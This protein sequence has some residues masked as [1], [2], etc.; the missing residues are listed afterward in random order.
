MNINPNTAQTICQILILVFAIL[1]V[2][3]CYGSYHFGKKAQEQQFNDVQKDREEKHNSM[4]STIEQSQSVSQKEKESLMPKLEV[5]LFTSHTKL[6]RPDGTSVAISTR[7]K[8]PLVE[9]Q[10]LISNTNNNSVLATD[11]RIKFFFSNQITKINAQ[12]QISSGQGSQVEAIRI[13]KEYEKGNSNLY[14][15]K[16]QDNPITNSLSLQIEKVSIDG[17]EINSNRA[18]FSCARWPRDVGFS[19]KII[20]DA[21]KTMAIKK[22]PSKL[23]TFEGKFFYEIKGNLFESTING[24]ILDSK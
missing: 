12:P 6:K 11:C 7:Y 4:V 2:T 5:K 22:T 14:E 24:K 10:L 16:Q 17:K 3:F 18:T 9:Y 13:Y 1:T 21:S 19:A 8:Y 20:I 23:G 15:E